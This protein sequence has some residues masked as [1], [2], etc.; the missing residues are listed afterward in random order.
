MPTRPELVA[1]GQAAQAP[2]QSE[3]LLKLPA[4]CPPLQTL[5]TDAAAPF[6]GIKESGLGREQSKYGISEFLEVR[7]KPP[8]ACWTV[9]SRRCSPSTPLGVIR[10][11]QQDASCS[12]G[13]QNCFARS[14]G[15]ICEG[16]LM[17]QHST[18]ITKVTL[19][20]RAGGLQVKFIC[21]GVG[22][23]GPR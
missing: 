14:L 23:S 8:A 6:G 15:C 19:K 3:L 2:R 11:L 7:Q 21:M 4:P 17:A 10:A 1:A 9:N 18:S 16:C 20:H 12:A 22:Y 13:T 5:I